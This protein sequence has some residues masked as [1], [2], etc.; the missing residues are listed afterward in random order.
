M[1]VQRHVC[2]QPLMNSSAFFPVSGLLLVRQFLCLVVVLSLVVLA[3]PAR[4]VE[5]QGL[6]S[7]AVP[8]TDEGAQSQKGDMSRALARVLVK[9]S[10]RQKVLSNP[11]IQKALR[12][13]ENYVQQF[14][15]R[16]GSGLDRQQY[17]QAD[18]NEEAINNLLRSAGL[19][20]WGAN[21]SPTII[22]LALDNGSGRSIVSS[23]GNL[24]AAFAGGFQDRGVPV[25]FPMLDVEDA[26]VI[27]AADLWGGFND[28]VSKASRRYGT[29]SILTGRLTRNG[30]LYNG[31]LTLLFRDSVARTSEVSGLD[32]AG[33]A[34]LAANLVGATLSDHYA[35]DASQ[36]SGNLVLLVENITNLEAYAALGSYLEQLTAIRDVSVRKVR[37][38][39]VELEL[40]VDGSQNQLVE[41]FALE[42]KL[43]PV[44]KPVDY[45]SKPAA[46][47]SEP[48]APPSESVA[49]P[50]EPEPMIYRWVFQRQR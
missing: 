10:G 28:V 5:V 16:S 12:E 38:N 13:P 39:T 49:P 19:A 41:T 21:R 9:V 48:V 45:L 36:N 18:F 1:P 11:A 4:A 46:P 20:I 31:R 34:G 6:Y 15:F 22:W 2:F 29:E 40:V 3:G 50:S 17:F 25:L 27:T 23:S 42:R 24:A 7:Q 47:P 14:G 8:V 32:G 37:G 33:V 44:A 30:E 43:V 35:I 26:S